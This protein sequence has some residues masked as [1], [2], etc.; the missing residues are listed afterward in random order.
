ML[1][2]YYHD[3][4]AALLPGYFA[5][6]NENSEPPPDNGLIQGTNYFN[7]STLD[8]SSGYNCTNSTQA[9]ISV[10]QGQ[11]Y[12]L[13]LINSGSIGEFQFSVDNHTLAVIEADGTVLEPVSVHRLEIAVA[14][15]YSV[16]LTAN[17]TAANYWIRATLNTF[18]FADNP[19][20]DPAIKGI[21]SYTNTTNTPT[22]N[23]SADWADALDTQ[24]VD[25]NAT[26]LVPLVAQV[27]PPADKMFV[28]DASFQIGANAIDHAF[29]NSTS[30]IP[31]S[32]PTLNQAVAGLAANNATFS[33]T[34]LSTAYD[35]STQFVID[36]SDYGVVDLLIN[37]F[38]EGAHPFHLH[39]HTFWVMATGLTGYFDYA[40]YGKLDTTN[41]LRRDTITI[42]AYG[43]VLIRFDASNPGL[44][45]LH[46]H[47][48][49]HM[50]AGLLMQFQARNDIMK[51]WTIPS[52]VLA[53]CNA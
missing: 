41:P 4:S 42:P 29:I 2:D 36:I 50:E 48:S 37:N 27:A 15:R 31:A 14:Q 22:N 35:T 19:L 21:L 8:P 49:W 28:V 53:L 6:G 51:T 7:C 40:S 47:I 43:W 44:W 32:V 46:C 30:W 45:P 16:I 26:T 20:L 25:L 5:S 11:R 1:Q 13:R 39:G 10:L 18:C 12:R 38:D 52:D 24:C 33:S 34:G 17:Q 23:Q 3:L 9:E